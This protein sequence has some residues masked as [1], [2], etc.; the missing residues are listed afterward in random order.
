M[1]KIHNAGDGKLYRDTRTWGYYHQNH[2]EKKAYFEGSSLEFLSI[3]VKEVFKDIKTWRE[4]YIEQKFVFNYPRFYN[5]FGNRKYVATWVHKYDQDAVDPIPFK[6]DEL[7]EYYLLR[8]KY[9]IYFYIRSIFDLVDFTVSVISL[10][11]WRAAKG[12]VFLP[13]RAYQF[14]NV[15]KVSNASLKSNINIVINN[16]HYNFSNRYI[17]PVIAMVNNIIHNCEA[18]LLSVGKGLVTWYSIPLVNLFDIEFKE[19]D[20]FWNFL[21]YVWNKITSKDSY[22]DL[23][24][25]LKDHP[26]EAYNITVYIIIRTWDGL[27]YCYDVVMYK[28]TNIF[29][30]LKEK[31]L[32]YCEPYLQEFHSRVEQIRGLYYKVGENASNIGISYNNLVNDY[33]FSN[34]VSVITSGFKFIISI[35]TSVG[36]MF[37]LFFIW[38]GFDFC[39]ACWNIIKSIPKLIYNL[40]ELYIFSKFSYNHFLEESFYYGG[41][42]FKMFYL[43]Y[44]A[45]YNTV[46][47]VVAAIIEYFATLIA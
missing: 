33:S 47:E 28:T 4:S 45:L 25:M 38:T 14:L 20:G 31:I 12:V 34:M 5:K 2:W 9:S 40:F 37:T 1:R 41:K 6:G 26:L 32:P 15:V 42:L 27:K 11:L 22:I 7:I 16:F 3:L 30:L 44:K 10:E 19:S 23:F 36:E 29:L 43:L 39:L 8:T 13:L 46:F 21:R 24:Y 35:L 18:F 17:F